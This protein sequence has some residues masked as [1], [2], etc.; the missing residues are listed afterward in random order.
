MSDSI[1]HT[2]FFELKKGVYWFALIS[3]CVWGSNTWAASPTS[4]P[5]TKQAKKAPNVYLCHAEVSRLFLVDFMKNPM[6][7][8]MSAR[9]VPHR[10]GGQIQGIRFL[11]VKKGSFYARLGL[12]HGDILHSVN[13]KK[14][15]IEQ[16]LVLYKK[17][18]YTRILNARIIRK[19]RIYK[20]VIRLHTRSKDGG[21][22]LGCRENTHVALKKRRAT[23]KPSV[24]RF[25]PNLYKTSLSYQARKIKKLKEH[26]Y[27]LPSSLTASRLAEDLIELAGGARVVPYFHRGR[28]VGFK[29]YGIKKGS[30]FERVGGRDGDIL[31]SINGHTM[32]SPQQAL[33][34]YEH[35]LK[36]KLWKCKIK[37]RGLV[38]TLVIAFSLK[39]YQAAYPPTTKATTKPTSR[40][41]IR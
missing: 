33:N 27:L 14:L 15:T 4:Q 37:R 9:I 32:F 7:Y 31:L 6:A 19:D 30:F 21:S 18:P 34:A 17:L 39:A 28:A 2:R 13:G 35:A 38:F 22:F 5:T 20:Y 3:I 26:H 25:L 40:G 8:A 10:A 41:T 23:S 12:K 36:V 1:R 16:A 24:R 11:W 29:F